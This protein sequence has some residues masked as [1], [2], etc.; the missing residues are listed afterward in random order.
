MSS[1]TAKMCIKI[2]CSI[3]VQ[4]VYQNLYVYFF[5][6]TVKTKLHKIFKPFLLQVIL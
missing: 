5:A 2:A 6:K 4:N 3:N 1:I